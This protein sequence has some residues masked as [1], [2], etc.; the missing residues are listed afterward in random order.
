MSKQ[1]GGSG[2]NITLYNGTYLLPGTDAMEATSESLVK[3]L[4]FS[5]LEKTP[6][7]KAARLRA[8]ILSDLRAVPQRVAQ[9]AE[10]LISRKHAFLIDVILVIGVSRPAPNC[11]APHQALAEQANDSTTI[12][13]LENICP[14][15]IYVPG[16]HEHPSAWESNAA[17]APR[18]TPTSY[19]AIAG[20]FRIAPDLYV[21]HRRFADGISDKP[22]HYLPL[23][24]RNT[25][26]AKFTRPPRFRIPTRP[27]AIV[28]CSSQLPDDRASK[29]N[30]IGLLRTVR[31]LL[32][33]SRL[34]LPNLDFILAVAPSKM[35]RVPNSSSV[36][37]MAE[38]SIDP[39]SF[40]DGHFC[41]TTFVRPDVWDP[42]VEPDID[43][44]QLEC[45]TAWEVENIT[46]Y[47]LDQ[48]LMDDGGHLDDIQSTKLEENIDEIDPNPDTENDQDGDD[49]FGGGSSSDSDGITIPYNTALS[50]QDHGHERHSSRTETHGTNPSNEQKLEKFKMPYDDDLPHMSRTDCGV[51]ESSYKSDLVIEGA[52]LKLCDSTLKPIESS[53]DTL[54][55]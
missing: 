9:L 27:S 20:P 23:S 2:T 52:S 14:R 34:T 47:N 7:R 38:R 21:V 24:W 17:A 1:A 33:L 55:G 28:L 30:G 26:Y 40:A 32:S 11:Q 25:M 10:W 51:Y 18:L 48:T 39:G 16:L 29:S 43:E 22:S 4:F 12:S 5:T 6:H 50:S 54:S 8:L 44:E 46:K 49:D 35:Q 41:I 36:F 42:D 13:Y 37:R 19:N 45:E 3:S 31:S 53:P 15:I